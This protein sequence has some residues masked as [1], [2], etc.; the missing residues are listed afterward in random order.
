MA[1]TLQNITHVYNNSIVVQH[2]LFEEGFAKSGGG[3][4][5][6]LVQALQD[7]SSNYANGTEHNL[8]VPAA[9]V[10]TVSLPRGQT[11]GLL[12]FTGC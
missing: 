4:F 7:Q 2:C 6:F 3:V 1:L 11:T 9:N 8:T 10:M 5:I 12:S